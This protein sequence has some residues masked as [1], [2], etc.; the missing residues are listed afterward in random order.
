MQNEI[1][2]LEK[3]TTS[4][5]TFRV[6]TSYNLVSGYPHAGITHCVGEL[7]YFRSEKL[8]F[9]SPVHAIKVYSGSRCIAPL[10]LNLDTGWKSVFNIKPQ[11]LYPRDGNTV[12]LNRALDGPQNHS[13]R[14]VEEKKIVSS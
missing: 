8:K 2:G 5:A 1:C 13:G 9:F 7:S 14:F 11:Q 3:L 12:A 4:I 6:T 10:I